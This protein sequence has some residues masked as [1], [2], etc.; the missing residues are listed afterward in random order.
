ML[1]FFHLQLKYSAFV[2]VRKNSNCS[3]SLPPAGTST[4]KTEYAV[5]HR[6]RAE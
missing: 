2:I 4:S 1:I 5:S 6:N 3:K